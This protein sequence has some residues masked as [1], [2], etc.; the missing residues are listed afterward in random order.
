MTIERDRHLASANG[1]FDPD[2]SNRER[3]KLTRKVYTD[4][5]KRLALY[6]EKGLLVKSGQDLCDCLQPVCPGCHLPCPKCTSPLCGHECRVN[7]KWMYD[8]VEIEG[9]DKVLRNRHRE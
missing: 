2:N 9:T 4:G 1:G 3:R 7:R 8:Q 6:D 5:R